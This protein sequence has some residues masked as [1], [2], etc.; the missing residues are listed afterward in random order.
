MPP[1]VSELMPCSFCA[2]APHSA[3]MPLVSELV[4]LVLRSCTAHS[5]LM[6]LV[7]CSCLP[8]VSAL[9][10]PSFLRS[11]PLVSALVKPHL[12]SCPAHS[13]LRSSMNRQPVFFIFRRGKEGFAKKK[14]TRWKKSFC[15]V[16]FEKM[17]TIENA[18]C[19]REKTTFF[20]ENRTFFRKNAFFFDFPLDNAQL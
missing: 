1:L 10:A 7:L 2:Y 3:L 18:P 8:L 13:E 16:F 19:F 15:T 14:R 12:R 9:M 6:P 4:P 17:K 5:E 11:C 20:K